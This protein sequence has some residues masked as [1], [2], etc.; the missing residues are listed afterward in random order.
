[1][2]SSQLDSISEQICEIFL[3]ILKQIRR[4]SKY[5]TPK[6]LEQF[7]QLIQKNNEN[8]LSERDKKSTMPIPSPP[9]PP[10][11]SSKKL[12]TAPPLPIMTIGKKLTPA[13]A[14]I[15][16][17]FKTSRNFDIPVSLKPKL[18]PPDG[19]K[20][21]HLQWTKISLNLFS[22]SP[23]NLPTNLEDSEE[24]NFM[25]NNSYAS[26]WQKMDNIDKILSKH[27]Y[28]TKVF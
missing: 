15:D 18:F 3:E 6:F 12:P 23:T 13:A 27:F 7:H 22:N 19:R 28:L 16:T 25:L 17:A 24:K 2:N 8:L 1:M 4:D 11:L 10:M 5:S 14:P 26:V 9:P 20:M 21:R